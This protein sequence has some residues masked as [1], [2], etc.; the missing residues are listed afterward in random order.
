[1]DRAGVAYTFV[2]YPGARHSF[3]KPGADALGQRF[4][5]PLA[6]NAEADRQSWEEMRR[7]LTG[8]FAP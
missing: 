4:G 6:Y 8:V 5:L 3:T 2:D 7:F 1:M